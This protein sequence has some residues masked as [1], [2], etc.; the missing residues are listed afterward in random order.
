[1]SQEPWTVSSIVWHCV[2]VVLNI[3]HLFVLCR[4]QGF[5]AKPFGKIIIAITISDIYLSTVTVLDTLQVTALIQTS[6]HTSSFIYAAWKSLRMSSIHMTYYACAV[7]CSERCMAFCAPFKH[8]TSAVVKNVGKIMLIGAV[9]MNLVYLGAHLL[10]PAVFEH[11]Q[12]VITTTAAGNATT[13]SNATATSFHTNNTSFVDVT[14]PMHKMK[15]PANP[16]SKQKKHDLAPASNLKNASRT[17]QVRASTTKPIDSD[18]GMDLTR[19]F[20]EGQSADCDIPVRQQAPDQKPPPPRPNHRPGHHGKQPQRPSHCK[21]EGD[22]P[23]KHP[24]NQHSSVE[25]KGFEFYFSLL[26]FHLQI[27]LMPAVLAMIITMPLMVWALIVKNRRRLDSVHH[28][29]SS[30]SRLRITTIYVIIISVISFVLLVPLFVL[31][32]L[33]RGQ[34]PHFVKLIFRFLHDGYGVLNVLIYGLLNRN[35]RKYVYS[36]FVNGKTESVNSSMKQSR[37]SSTPIW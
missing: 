26:F 12:D 27:Q 17:S 31:T 14:S 21:P 6:D 15:Q 36:M 33:R 4:R 11:G 3:F 29:T 18:V 8:R 23:H 34:V 1:M 5:K 9:S 30:D 32:R 16:L 7:S 13:M 24:R 28:T 20:T 25:T 35:Y 22:K 19:E 10:I 37:R 2:T